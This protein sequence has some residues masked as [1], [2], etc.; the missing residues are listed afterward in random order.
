[1]DHFYYNQEYRETIALSDG[2]SAVLRCVQPEDKVLLQEGLQRLS[3]DGRY[4]RFFSP[5]PVR[6]ERELKFL[7]EVD[8]VNHV[9][10]GALRQDQEGETGLAIARFIRLK[11][12][13]DTAEPAIAVVDEAQGK[14]LGTALFLRL[15][16]AARER[17][18]RRFRA[19]IL[20]GN[21][22]IKHLLR[23]LS[24]EVSI[25]PRGREEIIDVPIPDFSPANLEDHPAAVS[26]P[27]R[28]IMEALNSGG[29]LIRNTWRVLR[30]LLS[31]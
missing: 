13:P 25:E 21:E 20:A 29:L 7:T 31:N 18:I 27:F 28:Q 9:A 3:P 26:G 17:D 24:S 2:T 22:P 12:K 14:G 23:D 8:G 11:D 4:R 10:I 5:K 16:A 30:D 19:E 15:M 1:M 6:S